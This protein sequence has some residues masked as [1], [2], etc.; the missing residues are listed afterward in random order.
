MADIAYSDPLVFAGP[1]KGVEER[2]TFQSDAHCQIA[3][4]VSFHRGYIE[5]RKGLT[6][7]TVGGLRSNMT[8]G[9]RP[10]GPPRL[11]VCGFL[12]GATP[13]IILDICDVEMTSLASINLSTTFGEPQSTF[14]DVDF[15][16][17]TLTNGHNVVLIVTPNTTYVWDPYVNELTVRLV[18]M[19]TDT[20]KTDVLTFF[21]LDQPPKG[22]IV[23]QHQRRWYYAGFAPAT[24]LVL[25]GALP[26]LQ[27]DVPETWV[28]AG[29]DTI[30]V[31]PNVV[32]FSDTN[33]PFDIHATSFLV[34][35]Q[36]EKVTGLKSFHEQLVI[37]TDRA[38]YVL[39]G[40]PGIYGGTAQ[41][42]RVVY[43]SGCASPR[44]VAEVNG[45][46]YY[47]GFDGIYVFDGA[48]ATKLSK[49]IDS[50]WTGAY[51]GDRLPGEIESYMRANIGWP[52]RVDDRLL[53]LAP[54][55]HRLTENQVWFALPIRGQYHLTGGTFFPVVAVFD[56]VHEAWSFFRTDRAA[57]SGADF[58]SGATT[59]FDAGLERTYVS[60]GGQIAEYGRGTTDDA[61]T[62]IP[63]VYVSARHA[64][65]RERQTVWQVP[66][67]TM[68][69][70]GKTPTSN[71]PRWMLE[72]M[73][74][75]FDSQLAG[76]TVA[77]ADRQQWAA[78]L[79]MHPHQDNTYFLGTGTLGSSG[80]MLLSPQSWWSQRLQAG[81]VESKWFRLGFFDRS[82]DVGRPP[83]IVIQSY[84]M[85][86][87]LD[88][89]GMQ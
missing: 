6:R 52:W 37:F 66:F 62:S 57:S 74:A 14:F 67:V 29:R 25:D 8:V 36:S 76:T 87:D 53:H 73:E 26:A 72:G 65:A 55:I 88:Q 79:Q 18:A 70:V 11:L 22:P 27:E 85:L 1:W 60:Q 54:A 31:G 82:Q 9:H 42:L 30:R 19:A 39:A 33:Y 89:G 78:D 28:L 49:P 23:E 48:M 44:S 84:A 47:T 32:M 35:P 4:N 7:G 51:H 24:Q 20:V 56:Y 61:V 34:L 10:V 68:M 50:L 46:L 69:S 13:S 40:D 16:E 77:A 71:P 75:A 3:I 80:S 43:G 38:V 81:A 15:A 2:E 83:S 41:L 64:K 5:G 86:A 58:M 17:A 63:V 21:Y 45:R 59:Y 12:S